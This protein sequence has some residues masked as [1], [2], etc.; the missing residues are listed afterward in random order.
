MRE[1]AVLNNVMVD[2]FGLSS[3]PHTSRL[4]FQLPI[5]EMEQ[6]CDPVPQSREEEHEFRAQSQI[7][8]FEGK[9]FEFNPSFPLGILIS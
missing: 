7:T 6:H 8:I 9:N 1:K 4:L 2:R 5:C 3:F